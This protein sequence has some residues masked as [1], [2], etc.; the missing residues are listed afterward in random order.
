MSG[1]SKWLT[2]RRLVGAIMLAAAVVGGSAGAGFAL[3][4]STLQLARSQTLYVGRTGVALTPNGNPLLASAATDAG[5]RQGLF[6]QLFYYNWE[7]GRAVPWLASGY[8]YN[9]DYTTLTIDIR[10][11]VTWSDGKPFTSADVAYTLRLL[12]KYPTLVNASVVQTE[13]QSVQTHGL[14]SVEIQLKKPDRRFVGNV[15]AG[16]ISTGVT[17][18]PKHIFL[19]HYA[20]TFTFFDIKTGLPVGTGPYKLLSWDSTRGVFERR[21]DWWAAR[22]GFHKLPAPKYL[23]YQTVTPDIEAQSLITNKLDSSSGNINGLGTW[24]AISKKNKYLGT[25]SPT[26]WTDP[27]PISLE[28]NTQVKPWNDPQMRWALWYSIDKSKFSALFNQGSPYVTPYFFPDYPRLHQVIAD[29]TAVFKKY[30][31]TL[32]SPARAAQIL[33][34]HGY[35]QS[36]GKWADSSG[37]PLTVNL[38]IFSP[39]VA[40]SWGVAREVL[41]QQLGAAGFTVNSTALDF[42]GMFS[43]L[44]PG[45][46]DVITWFECGSVAE[47]WQSLNRYVNS[48]LAP[49]GQNN[50]TAN[51]VRWNNQQ[52]TNIV[53]KLATLPGFSPEAKKLTTH[54]L[55]IFARELPVGELTQA[56]KTIIFSTRYWTNW[57]TAKNPYFQPTPQLYMFLQVLLRLR[58]AAS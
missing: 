29:N 5:L 58:P 42:G 25:W 16:Y 56:V 9:A 52:Y 15:L 4:G 47:P 20:P 2:G 36:G 3:S 28:M 31:T 17:I 27:C 57:P 12:L 34:S 43:A 14:Y 44:L 7:N 26:G 41:T 23:V 38:T 6:E 32:Y 22:T 11:G 51:D 13:V 50:S 53:N 49:I 8:K 35:H 18:V 37:K 40:A 24:N 46:F 45:K 30:P 33:T 48:T 39:T 1:R 19:H 21:D 54:A 10:H 55:T